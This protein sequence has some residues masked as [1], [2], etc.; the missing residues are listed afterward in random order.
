MDETVKKYLTE[1]KQLGIE[2][3]VLEHPQLVSVEEVQKYLGYTMKDAGATLVM[4]AD[5]QFVAIIRRGDSKLDNEKVKKLLDIKNLRMANDEEFTKITGVPSGAASVYIKNIP[6]YIDR[7]VFEQEYINAGS[8][9]W[10]TSNLG[11]FL[12][13]SHS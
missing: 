5:S 2:V 12:I 9:A 11:K 1:L 13:I 3:Q 6:T 8:A 4:K 7:K 10:N